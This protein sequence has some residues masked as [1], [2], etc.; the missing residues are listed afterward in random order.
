MIRRHYYSSCHSKE[1]DGKSH[2]AADGNHVGGELLQP[3]ARRSGRGGAEQPA[4]VSVSGVGGRRIVP[5]RQ[6]EPRDTH[7]NA[8]EN[9]AQQKLRGI[10]VKAA[11]MALRPHAV[12]LEHCEG[13]DGAVDDREPA[14]GLHEKGEEAGTVGL[15]RDG[16]GRYLPREVWL[17]VGIAP[18]LPTLG[19]VLSTG[20]KTRP[21]AVRLPYGT[22][23][24]VYTH[25]HTHTHR[26]TSCS[27]HTHTHTHATTYTHTHTHTHKPTSCSYTHTQPITHTPSHSH[28]QTHVH[29]RT[30]TQ[31]HTHAAASTAEYSPSTTTTVAHK[32]YYSTTPRPMGTIVLP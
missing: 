13:H 24:T 21:T 4:Q 19:A 20:H 2:D 8:D 30:H 9:E 27:T 11:S 28:T 7:H 12:P 26:P 25:T 32:Y 14:L 18:L 15:R 3:T 23:T 17:L 6:E 31:S 10:T 29:R 16:L 1:H 22:D 5:V